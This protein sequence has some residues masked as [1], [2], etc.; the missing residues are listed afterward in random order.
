MESVSGPDKVV[1]HR[2]DEAGALWSERWCMTRN[3]NIL[4]ALARQGYSHRTIAEIAGVTLDGLRSLIGSNSSGT[5]CPPG[6]TTGEDLIAG[7]V[8]GHT[9]KAENLQ[10]LLHDAVI[11]E[12]SK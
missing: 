6:S 4:P 12:S 8:S 5:V 7:L 3:P 9:L 1:H 2:T 11:N 10:A